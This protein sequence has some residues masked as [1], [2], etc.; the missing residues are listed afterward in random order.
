MATRSSNPAFVIEPAAPPPSSARLLPALDGLRAFASLFVFNVHAFGYCLVTFYGWGDTEDR[1]FPG[2]SVE[3]LALWLHRS[4]FGVDLFFVLSGFLMARQFEFA[5]AR[6]TDFLARRAQRVL[7]AYV[8]SLALAAGARWWVD[9]TTFGL[10]NWLQNLGFLHG[11]LELGIQGINPVTWSMSYEVTFY[12]AVPLLAIGFAAARRD[13]LVHV[14][15]AATLLALILLIGNPLTRLHGYAWLFLVGIALARAPLQ[16]LRGPLF[17]WLAALSWL[18][19]VLLV[20]FVLVRNRE[21]A[22]YP[23][24]LLGSGGMLVLALNYGHTHPASPGRILQWIGDRSYSLFLLHSIV[25]YLLGAGLS[26]SLKSLDPALATLI[27][28]PS[29]LFISL[30][31]SALSYRIAEQPFYRNRQRGPAAP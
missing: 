10:S 25:V 26:P 8:L 15:F 29:A 23:A 22:Y 9:G 16:R 28:V 7:P 20:K 30:L 11:F 12:L 1:G 31:V 4:W 21:L 13:W 14:T 6:P 27:F 19:F 17:L 5:R 18:S 24:S 2:W 3:S